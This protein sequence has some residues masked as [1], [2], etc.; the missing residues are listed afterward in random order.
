MKA[1][2]DA[3]ISFSF[4]GGVF[5]NEGCSMSNQQDS[6]KRLSERGLHFRPLSQCLSSEI[7]FL[8]LAGGFGARAETGP[9]FAGLF[10][11]EPLTSDLTRL[12]VL[13]TTYIVHDASGDARKRPGCLPTKE[14]EN[15]AYKRYSGWL[16]S[17]LKYVALIVGS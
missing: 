13:S 8:C 11:F 17:A 4:T 2:R 14:Q 9:R 12:P 3:E 5:R 1:E 7:N 10:H 16:W 6:W 15:N